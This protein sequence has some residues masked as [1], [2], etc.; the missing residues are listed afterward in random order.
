MKR[1]IVRLGSFTLVTSIPSKW[2]KK[3]RLKAGD[4]IDVTEEKN[5]LVLS[6]EKSISESTKEIFV[7]KGQKD[8]QRR[9]YNTYRS[10][11]SKIIVRYD[12]PI[13]IREINKLLPILMGF[14][15]TQQEKNTTILSDVMKIDEKHFEQTLK[16]YFNSRRVICRFKR[17]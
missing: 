14:E 7:K 11:V 15:I 10:G 8:F 6:V 9:L 5:N 17:K 12:D 3:N 16:R 13:I 2:A 1:K 4:E